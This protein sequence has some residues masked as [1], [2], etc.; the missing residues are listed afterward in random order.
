MVISALYNAIH[1]CQLDISLLN[2]GVETFDPGYHAYCHY[3][4]TE[5]SQSHPLMRA[6]CLLLL[7][8]TKP[9]GP[10]EPRMGDLEEGLQLMHTKKA[11]SGGGRLKRS[12][13]RWWLAYTLLNNPS[14]MTCR[15]T[16]LCDPTANGAQLSP[17]RP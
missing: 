5:V 14:L 10:P 11:P 16:A 4:K 17:P 9:Q 13:A 1:F 12:R 3:L 6:F 8:P 15:K 2:R 7:Q